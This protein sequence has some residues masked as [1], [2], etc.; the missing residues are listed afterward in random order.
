MNFGHRATR[1]DTRQP[2]DLIK[3]HLQRT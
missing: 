2:P 3:A 1:I